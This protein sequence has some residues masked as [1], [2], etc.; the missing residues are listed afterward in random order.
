[1]EKYASIQYLKDSI[2][3]DAWSWVIDTLNVL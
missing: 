3:E 1:M 2:P